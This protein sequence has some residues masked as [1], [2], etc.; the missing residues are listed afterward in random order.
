MGIPR[1]PPTEDT[2]TDKRKLR[3]STMITMATSTRK[4]KRRGFG[5]NERDGRA[6]CTNCDFLDLPYPRG[7]SMGYEQSSCIDS[8]LFRLL[9]FDF[10]DFILSLLVLIFDFSGNYTPSRRHW[11]NFSISLKIFF[12]YK[13]RRDSQ[14]LSYL[15]FLLLQTSHSLNTTMQFSNVIVPAVVAATVSAAA[16]V[17]IT[18]DVV[19]TDFVTYCPEPT[20]FVV[21]NKTITVTEATTL[22]I[23]GP[24]TIPTTI[25]TTEAKKTTAPSVTTA[26][27]GAGKIA[28]G[29]AAGVAAVA[30]ALF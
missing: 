30:A 5:D 27:N 7:I 14:I 21:N 25:T 4:V 19:V 10:D 20:H 26:T 2:C 15:S 13:L 11:K 28:V 22:T 24:C 29:A 9:S 8:F 3:T 6:N 17:T 12:G 16:N 18:T 1:T 23:T